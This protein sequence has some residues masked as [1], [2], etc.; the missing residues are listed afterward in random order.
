M[1]VS[2]SRS[3]S[4][5][6]GESGSPDGD[7]HWLVDGYNV[8]HAALL[9][10]ELRT[11]VRW[12]DEEGRKRLIR[13][14]CSFDPDQRRRSDN[15]IS[16]PESKADLEEQTRPSTWTV[17][18]VFDGD[19]DP[20]EDPALPAH[21]RIVFAPSA[22]DYLVSRSRRAEANES[23]YVVSS[24]KRVVGR[25]AHAGARIIKPVD[26]LARCLELQDPDPSPTE[27]I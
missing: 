22:D 17:W 4:R 25:C 23:I 1:N 2:P 16:S 24:D 14:V 12:W 21:I 27:A 20:P 3:P 18:V 19:R 5:D 10:G 7:S 26:F 8:L 6:S 9:P 15:D 13:R 11:Q